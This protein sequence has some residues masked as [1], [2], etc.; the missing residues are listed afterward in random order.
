MIVKAKQIPLFL[1]KLQA[2]SPRIRP[3][4]IKHPFIKEDLARYLAGY[5]GEKAIEYY[6]SFLPDDEYYILHDIR[7]FDGQHYF[8]ID[9]LIL[10]K[11]LLCILEI[12]YMAGII[13]FD[14]DFDQIIQMKNGQEKAF[15]DPINQLQRQKSQ[16]NTWLKRN[17]LPQL[18][19][20][21]FVVFSNPQTV[22]KSDDRY[23][24]NSVIKSHTLQSKIT[25]HYHQHKSDILTQK[26]IK[27]FIK[28][29]M[30]L[31]TPLDHSVLN[32]YQLSR[33]DILTG[34]F[35]E[36]CGHLALE[37]IHGYW[38]CSQC[39][40]K[41]KDAHL[42]ALKDYQLLFG[43]S[44]TSNQLKEFLQIECSSLSTRILNAVAVST[45]GEKKGRIHTLSNK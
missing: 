43:D 10:T 7:L 9:A 21:G 22:I 37:R 23:T 4:H 3:H 20:Q 2:L 27:K 40:A 41:S 12:K 15:P 34:V 38:M 25:D 29:T 24:K 18:P 17:N 31:N 14:R 8:Q 16:L 26:E 1:L 45:K 44:I 13:E 33:S 28:K 39:M 19:I 11:R 32:Q 6:L 36:S 42:A 30:K 35:C 5:K